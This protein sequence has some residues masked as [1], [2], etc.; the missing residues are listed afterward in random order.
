M[1]KSTGSKARRKP[2][3]PS[4]KFPLFAHPSGQWARKINKRLHYFG[5]WADPEAALD[6]H[7]REYPYLKKG[8]TPPPVDVSS[9]CTLR[10]LVNDFLRSKEE[11]LKAGDLSPRTFRDYYQTCEGLIGHFGR[12]RL[13]S[14]LRPDDFRD[15]RAKLVKRLGVVSLKNEIN[16]V[17]IIFNYA[18]ENNLIDRPVSYG[19]CFDRPS[20]KAIR[21]DRNEAG[22]KLFERD[23]VL[24]LLDAADVQLKAMI[25][26]GVNCGFGNTDVASLPLSAVNLSA[27]WVNFPRPKTEIPR[28]VPLWPETVAALRESFAARPAAVEPAARGLCFVTRHGRPWVRVKPKKAKKVEAE[29]EAGKSDGKEA[30]P[31]A[32]V[33]IDAIS[34][35]FGKLLKELEIN[36]RRGLGFYTLRHCFETFAGESTDQVAVDAVMGHV[37]P[38]MAGNYRHRISDERLRAVTEHVRAWLFGAGPDDGTTGEPEGTVPEASDPSELPN[39]PE[40]DEGERPALRLFVG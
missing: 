5:V 23:E 3:K 14:D 10:Q 40:Q 30:G 26:L 21:R 2:D 15:F 31:E 29:G 20:A 35:R 13:V 7:D 28:R 8:E 22:P 37:D 33:P 16:R 32:A 27:G 34:G 38:S 1:S 39:P 24:G 19:Q 4:K 18:H 9:G 25:L 11:K 17:C 6:R 12:E 36:G